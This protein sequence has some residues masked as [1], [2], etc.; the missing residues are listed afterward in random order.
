MTDE[1]LTTRP[2]PF[3]AALSPEPFLP[4]KRRDSELQSHAVHQ[5]GVTRVAA[6]AFE[7]EPPC[8]SRQLAAALLKIPFEPRER[9]IF[10][11]ETG[12]HSS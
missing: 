1:S 6:E 9:L 5:I 11:P 2:H 12:I 3:Q 7:M 10:I 8:N 4:P